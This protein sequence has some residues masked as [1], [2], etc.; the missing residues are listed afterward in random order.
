MARLIG[1]DVGGTKVALA[2]LEDAR[3]GETALRPTE[4]SSPDALVEQLVDSLE[5]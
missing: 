5:H 1:V 3:L 4:T 2:A